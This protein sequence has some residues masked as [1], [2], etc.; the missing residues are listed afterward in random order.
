VKAHTINPEGSR[1]LQRDVMRFSFGWLSLAN[2]VGLILSVLLL[3]PDLGSLMSPFT[4]GRL[5]PLHMEWHLY[6]W[7]SL[8]L[9]GLLLKEFL[10]DAPATVADIRFA[11]VAWSSGLLVGGVGYLSGQASGKLFLS[12]SGLSRAYFPIALILVWSVLATHW[13]RHWRNPAVTRAR[14]VL[15]ALL[16]L[17]LL[18]IPIM[19]YEFSSRSVYPPVDPQSGGAT[20]HSLLAS[21]LG[22]AGV[23]AAVPPL[24]GLKRKTSPAPVYFWIVYLALWG[25]YLLIQHGNAPNDAF[26]QWAG[27]GGLIVLIPFVWAYVWTWKWAEGTETWVGAFLFWWSILTVDGWITFLP[28]FLD[29]MKF[30]NA[31]V[32]HAHLA[33]AGMMTSF[34]IVMLG[35]LHGSGNSCPEY[36]RSRLAFLL[37]NGACLVMVVV[38]QVQGWREGANPG[39]LFGHDSLTGLVY[40][41]RAVAGAVMF[42]TGG[43]WFW[44]SLKGMDAV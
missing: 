25:V 28:G 4:Y 9:V 44:S 39:V 8:P 42:G 17:V 22:L 7:C 23:L 18:T 27:L 2:L 26:G 14:Q 35:S 21:T 3:F 24:L 43:W 31:M 1:A 37:W 34:G 41:I 33:M 19:L 6:G 36:L 29:R 16:L 38:L 10:D 30:T 15:R 13:I 5:I 40:L 11:L 32:A 12:W 20:G